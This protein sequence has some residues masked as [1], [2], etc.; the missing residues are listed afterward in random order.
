MKIKDY[1]CPDCKSDEFFFNWKKS[2]PHI[3]IYCQ[4][5]GKWL[6]W[7]NKNERNLADMRGNADE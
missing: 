5:C 3:G 7:A 6:K 1:K 2:E 4:R